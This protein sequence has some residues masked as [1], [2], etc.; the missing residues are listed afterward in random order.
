MLGAGV[1]GESVRKENRK[2]GNDKLINKV[3]TD[4]VKFWFVGCGWWL[5]AS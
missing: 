3:L 5:D 2:Q 1:K 4:K